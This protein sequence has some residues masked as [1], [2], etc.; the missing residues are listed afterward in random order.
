M[1]SDVAGQAPVWP[2][3]GQHKAPQSPPKPERRYMLNARYDRPLKSVSG[4]GKHGIFH[5]PY[6]SRFGAQSQ[7]IQGL[8][9]PDHSSS[10]GEHFVPI[11]IQKTGSTRSS[12]T[13]RGDP[14]TSPHIR[15]PATLAPARRGCLA[16]LFSPLFS[17]RAGIPP[18]GVESARRT[19]NRAVVRGGVRGASR[20]SPP[21]CQ[22]EGN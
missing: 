4:R 1:V 12:S 13:L 11:S 5:L 2:A 21:T 18:A 19:G 7:A 17:D 10:Y 6:S 20:G 22:R 15:A 3:N 14:R 16:Q 8:S 9:S